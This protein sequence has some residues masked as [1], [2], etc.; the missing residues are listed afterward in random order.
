MCL[1]AGLEPRYY[2][3]LPER[4]WEVD[5]AQLDS[6]ADEGTVALLIC[7]PG[8]PCGQ[9]FSEV[10]LREVSGK[11]LVEQERREE[12]SQVAEILSIMNIQFF[13]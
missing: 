11:H 2:D 1:H 3:L 12:L 7:N 10:H 6:L 8:N 13:M 4:N 9:V 5:V